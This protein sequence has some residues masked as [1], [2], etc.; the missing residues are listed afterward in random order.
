MEV[1][2]RDSSAVYGM[3]RISI[4]IY[5]IGPTLYHQHYHGIIGLVVEPSGNRDQRC[6]H[7]KVIK[8][9]FSS[10]MLSKEEVEITCG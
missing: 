9:T 2:S 5:V 3:K 10:A 1:A 7:L 6:C 8:A 4:L